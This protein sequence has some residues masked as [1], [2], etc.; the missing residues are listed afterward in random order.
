LLE[1]VIDAFVALLLEVSLPKPSRHLE[2]LLLMQV[3]CVLV[4]AR[5]EQ[6]FKSP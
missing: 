3:P 4:A 6:P 1:V 2:K 5:G